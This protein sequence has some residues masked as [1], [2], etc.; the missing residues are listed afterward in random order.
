MS[1]VEHR[2][3]L[4]INNRLTHGANESLHRDS[5]L[6]LRMAAAGVSYRNDRSARQNI[7]GLQHMAVWLRMKP[8]LEHV[9]TFMDVDE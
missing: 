4:E 3:A 9:W 1:D 6:A 7:A 8:Y 2:L 5:Q